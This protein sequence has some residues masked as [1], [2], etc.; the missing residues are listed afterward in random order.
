MDWQLIAQL[1]SLAK[2][3]IAI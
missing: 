1:V 3:L 2:T